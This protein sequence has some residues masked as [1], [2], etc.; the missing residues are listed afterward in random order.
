MA[1]NSD[2][3]VII[4]GGGPAAFGCH[5]SG[6]RSPRFLLT[7]DNSVIGCQFIKHYF[8]HYILGGCPWV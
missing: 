2:Y 6:P 8:L 3:D 4:V 7:R 1:G 5:E